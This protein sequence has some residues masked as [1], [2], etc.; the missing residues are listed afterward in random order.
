MRHVGHAVHIHIHTRARARGRKDVEDGEK[1]TSYLKRNDRK[2]VSSDSAT[3][4]IQDNE[5]LLEYFMGKYITLEMSSKDV[6]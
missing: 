6:G 3:F 5:F 4:C 2:G 1:P